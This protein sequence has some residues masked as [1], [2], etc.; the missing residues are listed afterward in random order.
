MF[1]ELLN[2]S[3]LEVTIFNVRLHEKFV[4]G[5]HVQ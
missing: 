3:P 5:N 1:T 2:E 4:G